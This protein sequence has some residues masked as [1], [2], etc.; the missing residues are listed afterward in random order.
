[1]GCLDEVVIAAPCP[2][3]WDEMKGDDRVRHC[4]G[5]AKNV[6]NIADMTQREAENFLEENGTTQCLRIFRRTDGKIMTD[7]C[8]KGLRAIRNRLRSCWKIAVGIAATFFAFVPGGRGQDAF[9]QQASPQAPENKNSDPKIELRGDVY[10]PPKNSKTPVLAPYSGKPMAI[11]LETKGE[12]YV[13]PAKGTKGIETVGDMINP[14]KGHKQIMLGGESCQSS[15]QGATNA[16]PLIQPAP[17]H[18]MGRAV[19]V[20]HSNM[21]AGNL[22]HAS[23]TP[24]KSDSKAYK[25]YMEAKAFEDQGKLLLAQVKYQ[26][27]IKAAKLQNQGDPN[28]MLLLSNQYA[29]LQAKLKSVAD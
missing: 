3:S 23:D 20:P 13:P 14:G 19:A 9:G 27:A 26:E 21:P 8:P 2:M 25:L 7:N 10:V 6:Y 18:R 22:E 4:C 29:K 24:K 5:C 15:G 28:F 12:S 1:M 11:P 16:Q 17:I